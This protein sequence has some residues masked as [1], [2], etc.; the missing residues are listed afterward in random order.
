[1]VSA[2]KP[3]QQPMVLQGPAGMSLFGV[4][5]DGLVDAAQFV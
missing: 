3:Q 2:I 5:A 4:G 1:M